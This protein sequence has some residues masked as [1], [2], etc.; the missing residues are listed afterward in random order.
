[1]SNAANSLSRLVTPEVYQAERTNLFP[2]PSS[3]RWFVRTHRKEL[4]DANALLRINGRH[5]VDPDAFDRVTLEAGRVDAGA[6]T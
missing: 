3:V 2:S 4:V 1:M 6:L 5:V